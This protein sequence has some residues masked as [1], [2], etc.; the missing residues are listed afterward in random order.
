MSDKSVFV[1]DPSKTLLSHS[2]CGGRL[3]LRF[4]APKGVIMNALADAFATQSSFG[5]S[6]RKLHFFL[7]WSTV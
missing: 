3:P 4:A 6:I 7:I 2:A 5:G 1:L